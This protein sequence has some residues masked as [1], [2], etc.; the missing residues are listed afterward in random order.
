[1]ADILKLVVNFAKITKDFNV[2]NNFNFKD[3]NMI[4]F[5]SLHLDLS[6]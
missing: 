6:G 5:E 2:V 4:S 1:M 3:S